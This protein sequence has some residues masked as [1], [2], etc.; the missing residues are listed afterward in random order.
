MA[1]DVL[2]SAQGSL[3]VCAQASKGTAADWTKHGRQK[4]TAQ[5]DMPSS[6]PCSSGVLRAS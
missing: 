2:S 3:W 4:H 6:G 5:G 1:D